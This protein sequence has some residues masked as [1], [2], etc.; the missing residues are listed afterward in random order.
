MLDHT[1][2]QCKAHLE[3]YQKDGPGPLIQSYLDRIHPPKELI[4]LDETKNHR[5]NSSRP[6]QKLFNLKRRQIHGIELLK[7]DLYY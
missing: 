4:N 7:I 1:C 2:A 5:M 6:I 3:L